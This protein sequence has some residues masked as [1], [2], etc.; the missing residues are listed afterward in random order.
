[1]NGNN[2]S[3]GR[4]LYDESVDDNDNGSGGGGPASMIDGENDRAGVATGG[5][6]EGNRLRSCPVCN[7]GIGRGVGI[8]R[9]AFIVNA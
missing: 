6:D 1:M 4:A 5:D 3:S 2:Y 7:D 9:V 8:R